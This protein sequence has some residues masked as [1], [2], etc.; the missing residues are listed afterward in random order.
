MSYNHGVRTQEAPTSIAPPV[1]SLAGLPIYFGTAPVNLAKKPLVNEPVLAY[2]Y[3]EAVEKLGF[4]ENFESY[5]LSEAMDLQF[6][7]FKVGPA[8]FVNVLDPAKHKKEGSLEVSVKDGTATIKQEGVLVESLKVKK[9]E[10]EETIEIEFEQEFDDDGF[11]NLFIEKDGDY[12]IEYSALDPEAVTPSDI[13]G[14]VSQGGSYKGLELINHIFPLF[15]LVPGA[16]AAPKFSA[17][18]EVAAVMTAK[19]NNINGLF[20]AMAL[21]DVSTEDVKDYTEVAAYK[22]DNNLTSTYQAVCWPKTKL[23]GKQYHL[24][25]QMASVMLV[26]DADH[27]GVPYKSPSNENLQADGAVLSDGTEITLGQDQ[28]AYLNGQGI[29]TPLNFIGGWKLWGNRTAAYPAVTDPKDSF[30][31]IRRMFNYVQNNLILT[32]WQ[33]VDDPTNRKLVESVVDTEN[34]NLNGMTA[35]GHILGGRVEFQE[36]MNPETS[37]MDGSMKFKLYMTP[38]PPA[39]EIV[40][41]VEFDPRY[42]GTLFG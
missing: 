9:I 3:G 42:L 26:T 39:R 8:V 37:L 4:S 34:I 6:G 30:I 13:V 35:A 33:K 40:F 28:A 2:E 14:G 7:K 41:D 23:G 16:I 21:V 29:I 24:S 20:K 10:D 17:D 11:L 1:I 12:S 27:E 22:N 5:T 36:T 19:S 38:P 32:Y 31:P 25:T 15:R 18:S